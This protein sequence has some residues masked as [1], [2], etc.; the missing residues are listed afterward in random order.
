[1]RKICGKKAFEGARAVFF[2]EGG[3]EAKKWSAAWS[4]STMRTAKG[5][6]Y[7]RRLRKSKEYGFKLVSA[8]K[9]GDSVIGQKASEKDG[10]AMFAKFK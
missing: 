5:F 4:P 6:L 7:T 3:P 10:P 9:G 2:P 1:M 8:P